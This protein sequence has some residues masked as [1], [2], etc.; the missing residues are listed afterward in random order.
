MSGSIDRDSLWLC[1]VCDGMRRHLISTGRRCG[2]V[3]LHRG[4]DKEG[5]AFRDWG[6]G[7]RGCGF[8]KGASGAS[9][10]TAEKHV[11][12]YV[13]SSLRI[14]RIQVQSIQKSSERI[15][16]ERIQ[17]YPETSEFSLNECLALSRARDVRLSQVCKQTRLQK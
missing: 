10:L 1:V 4:G 17:M 16:L 7:S 5:S 11:H 3:G 9:D 2:E 13:I 15:Q 6:L 14:E 12:T 8:E